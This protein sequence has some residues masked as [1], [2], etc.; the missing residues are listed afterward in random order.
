MMSRFALIILLIFSV[1]SAHAE[2]RYL[3]FAAASMKD[4]MEEIATS[5]EADTGDKLILSIAGTSKLARQI[6]HGAPADLFISADEQWMKWLS[7]RGH[8][9]KEDQAIITGNQLVVA[10]R[11]EIENWADPVAMLTKGIAVMADP[12]A[13]PAGRYA[14][15]AL[16]K[17]G[18]WKD[19]SKTIVR[20]E[21]VRLALALVARGEVE[22][23][24]VYRSDVYAEPNLRTAFLF[25]ETTHQKINYPAGILHSAKKGASKVLEYLLSPKAKKI[26]IKHGFQPR[27]N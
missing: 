24:I 12:D 1:S 20:T 17:M 16:T 6:D 13:I 26:F 22:A 11:R 3:V 10:V 23:A 5:F 15:Q 19:V 14:K 27:K 7:D 8:I 9:A 21:N 18:I 4:A 25:T 2:T